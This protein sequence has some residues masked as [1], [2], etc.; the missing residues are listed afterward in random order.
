MKQLYSFTT[1]S[2]NYQ[3]FNFNT[4][5]MEIHEI[6]SRLTLQTVLHHYNLTPDKNN[7]LCC[8]WHDDKTPSLQLYP[9]TNTW[10]CFSSNCTAGSGDVIDFVMR[11]EK[12]T[13]HE[14]LVKCKE[15][16]G[17]APKP[18]AKPKPSTKTI[19]DDLS[20]IAVLSKFYNG[21]KNTFKRSED[22]RA[23]ALLLKVFLRPL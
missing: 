18:T 6:K 22:A 13:K 15:L 20:R 10:T 23:Y 2:Y 16:I 21:R 14:A 1:K 4:Y 17:S 12:G 11:M 3:I 19:S 9:K 5:A 8:P 7:R